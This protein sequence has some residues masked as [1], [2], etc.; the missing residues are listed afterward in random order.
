MTKRAAKY[1]STNTGTIELQ[2]GEKKTRKTKDIEWFLSKKQLNS[3]EYFAWK[4]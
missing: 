4:K 2:K 3:L 1:L